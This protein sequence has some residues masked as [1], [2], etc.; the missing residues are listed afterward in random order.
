MS[1][2]CCAAGCTK[3]VDLNLSNKI[4]LGDGTVQITALCKE[5]AVKSKKSASSP[6]TFSEELASTSDGD[7]FYFG[8]PVIP[9]QSAGYEKSDVFDSFKI[10]MS[11]LMNMLTKY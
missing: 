2:R 4:I 11:F 8:A 1:K 9:V 6:L 10:A 3:W 7:F 5:H